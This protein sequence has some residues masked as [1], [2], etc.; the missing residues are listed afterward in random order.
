M[1]LKYL[2]LLFL[3]IPV[4]TFSQL[5]GA[6]ELKDKGDPGE[7]AILIIS[8]NYMSVA[9]FNTQSPNFIRTFGGAYLV[10]GDKLILNME[11]DTKDTNSIGKDIV[12]TF[13][14]SEVD[15]ELDHTTKVIWK[16]IQETSS[17]L[18]G[19]WRITDRLGQDGMLSPMPQGDRKTLKIMSG[20]RFQWFAINPKTKQFSGTGGGTY[21]LVDRKYTEKIDFFSRDKS[22][23]GAELSFEANIDGRKWTHKG[24]SST[25]NSVHEVWTKQ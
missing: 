1:R 14:S 7:L 22:R 16:K 20:S 9:V 25:G 10:K 3:F 12:Y 2:S 17:P 4:L 15:L 19:C 6:Y 23:V 5:I 24:K 8:E 13:K 11:F 18:S 21:T